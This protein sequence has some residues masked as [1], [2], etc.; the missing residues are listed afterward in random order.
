MDMSIEDAE[1]FECGCGHTVCVSHQLEPSVST[2]LEALFEEA[3]RNEWLLKRL[4]QKRTEIEKCAEEG[5]FIYEIL[6]VA[7]GDD[8]FYNVPACCCPICQLHKVL[9]QDAYN[10]LLAQVGRTHEDVVK[11]ITEKFG[12]LAEVYLYLKE[13]KE[14]NESPYWVR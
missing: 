4:E 12:T 7:L 10:Y 13:K 6:E 1:M 5:G 8:A 14:S 3:S 2:L 11:E 9:L